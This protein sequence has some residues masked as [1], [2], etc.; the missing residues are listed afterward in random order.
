MP[1]DRAKIACLK[2]A[3]VRETFM[4]G[5]RSACKKQASSGLETSSEVFAW[6]LAATLAWRRKST[7]ALC[8]S[9]AE[10]PIQVFSN[11]V[12]TKLEL[13]L[14]LSSFCQQDGRCLSHQGVNGAWGIKNT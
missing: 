12:Q 10:N 3:G 11:M 7:G 14:K 5:L 6:L 13:N 1:I 2:R 9:S 8:V 4:H